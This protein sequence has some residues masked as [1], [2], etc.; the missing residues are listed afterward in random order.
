MSLLI[1][2]TATNLVLH[3]GLTYRP[4]RHTQGLGCVPRP[5]QTHGEG[6]HRPPH[7][8]KKEDGGRNETQA[9]RK[10]IL[11]SLTRSQRVIASQAYLDFGVYDL[12]GHIQH[13]IIALNELG[14]VDLSGNLHMKTV[15]EAGATRSAE[16]NSKI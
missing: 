5:K 12:D 7:A 16:D 8:A 1:P 3:S 13:A 11:L 2:R 14:T 9:G 15:G 10:E 4:S 6:R